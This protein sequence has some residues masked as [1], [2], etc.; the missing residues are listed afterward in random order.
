M[1]AVLVGIGFAVLA[2]AVTLVFLG[3]RLRRYEQPKERTKADEQLT[4]D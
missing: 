3:R 2:V 1:M 4:W